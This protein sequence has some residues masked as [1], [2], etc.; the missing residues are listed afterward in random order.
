MGI[1]CY[2]RRDEMN[3]GKAMEEGGAR[4]QE[5]PN[6]LSCREP[7]WLNAPSETNA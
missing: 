2:M 7:E 4:E 6:P 3:A 1:Y 5:D